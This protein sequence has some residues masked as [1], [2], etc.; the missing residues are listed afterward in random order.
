M[1]NESTIARMAGNMAAGWAARGWDFSQVA[2][3]TVRCAR[4]I[5]AEVER[6]NPPLPQL[7]PMPKRQS[8]VFLGDDIHT[9]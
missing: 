8:G 9:P 5:A 7:A 4:E 3:D 1:I 2:R 6:T